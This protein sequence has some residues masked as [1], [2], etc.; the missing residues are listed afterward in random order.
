MDTI[1]EGYHNFFFYC[2]IISMEI[3]CEGVMKVSVIFP[4]QKHKWKKVR[5]FF[6]C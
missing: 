3:E 5:D 6:S 2:L 4:E 1:V